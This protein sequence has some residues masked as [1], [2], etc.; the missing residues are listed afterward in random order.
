ML[1]AH[2]NREPQ[3]AIKKLE[4]PHSSVKK[5]KKGKKTSDTA[6]EQVQTQAYPNDPYNYGPQP[7]FPWGGALALDLALIAFLFLLF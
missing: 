5:N 6:V 3:A 4:K 2:M 1:N 7:F